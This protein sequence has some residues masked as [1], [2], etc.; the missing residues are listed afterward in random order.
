ME[1]NF[2][3]EA[4]KFIVF[5]DFVV[6]ILFAFFPCGERECCTGIIQYQIKQFSNPL[7]FVSNYVMNKVNRKHAMKLRQMYF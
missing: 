5:V 1:I 7:G 3:T 4:V 6:N 2:E